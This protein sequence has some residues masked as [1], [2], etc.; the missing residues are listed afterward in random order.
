MV[1]NNQKSRELQVITAFIAVFF[2]INLTLTGCTA[3]TKSNSKTDTDEPD[4]DV[5]IW[6][7]EKGEF[8]DIDDLD[9]GTEDADQKSNV[10]ASE[11]ADQKSNV[12]ASED[13]DQ[14]SNVGASEDADQPEQNDYEDSSSAPSTTY[15]AGNGYD[16]YDEGYNAILD[17]DDYD[18]D[19]Y[20]NDDEYANGVDDALDEEEDDEGW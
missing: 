20:E 13:A 4:P 12:E 2:I 6:S 9:D 16:K 1:M 19:R 5:Q 8:L 18:W 3:M 7:G 15:N 14:K 17:D 10:E 11:D